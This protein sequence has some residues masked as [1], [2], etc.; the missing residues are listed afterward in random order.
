[1]GRD[2]TLA[3]VLQLQHDADMILSNLQ[4][5]G[6]FVTS[7]NRMSVGGHVRGIRPGAVSDRGS[8]VCGAVSPRSTGGALHGGHGRVASTVY[9]GDT[10]TSAVVIMQWVHDVL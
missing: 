2:R 7:L 10:G 6:Q 5:L 1:M 8:T 3:A 4:V 9:T